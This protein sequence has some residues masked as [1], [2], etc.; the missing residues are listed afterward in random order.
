MAIGAPTANEAPSPGLVSDTTGGWFG[1]GAFDV[2]KLRT[3][4]SAVRFAI[5]FETI[6]Q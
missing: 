6:F 5:V 1:G 4:P 3:G 2:V